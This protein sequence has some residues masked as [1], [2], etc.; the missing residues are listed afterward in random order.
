MMKAKLTIETKDGTFAAFYSGR[1]L[2]QLNFPHQQSAAKENEVPPVPAPVK[3]WHSQTARALNAAL[4]GKPVAE[5]PPLDLRG[6]T[7]FQQKVWAKLRQI[8]V[9][10]TKSYGEIAA[11]L[12]RP[13][14]SRAV[15]GACG[16]NPIPVLVP[17]HRILAANQKL[18][19]FSGGLDWKR[20]LLQREGI[21]K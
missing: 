7:E 15:G 5:L 8:G 20:A 9:G 1:G 6:G 18:G 21:F 13:K 11:S 3:E 19:G 14:A 4:A 10:R 12:G 2:A 16:A 17:C